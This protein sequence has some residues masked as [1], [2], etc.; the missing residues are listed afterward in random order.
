MRRP[1][2]ALGR[3]AT[4]KKKLKE[5][6]QH[7]VDIFYPSLPI[8]CASFSSIP[9]SVLS[10]VNPLRSETSLQISS[11]TVLINFVVQLVMRLAIVDN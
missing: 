8:I 11:I 1:W 3:S 2:P 9:L 5:I 6:L 4:G 10:F 7:V